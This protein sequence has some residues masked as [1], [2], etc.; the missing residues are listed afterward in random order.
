M[1]V[2]CSNGQIGY[3]RRRRREISTIPADPNKIFEIT[4]TSFIKV[5]YEDGSENFE[6]VIK[7][8]TKIFNNKKLIVGNQITD[9]KIFRMDEA[10]PS[11]LNVMK[12]KEEERYTS[13]MADESSSAQQIG[14][15][16]TALLLVAVFR[17]FL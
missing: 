4:I 16:G 1:Q 5:N 3:G 7:N 2:E 11:N 10:N 8:Q 14:Y 13:I 12:I 17:L 15:P 9:N 6:E